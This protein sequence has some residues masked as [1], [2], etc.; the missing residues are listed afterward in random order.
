MI[1]NDI[2]IF[3][4]MANEEKNVLKFILELL[5]YKKYFRRFKCFIISIP[6]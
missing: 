3:T 4:P 6:S 2:A 5:S 1:K